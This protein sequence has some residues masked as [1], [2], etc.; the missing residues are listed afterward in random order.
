[1]N[2]PQSLDLI[3]HIYILKD[4]T[5]FLIRQAHEGVRFLMRQNPCNPEAII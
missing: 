1:M 2:E 5:L 3:S 4:R